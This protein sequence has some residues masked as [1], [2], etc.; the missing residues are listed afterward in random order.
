MLLRDCVAFT[1][2]LSEALEDTIAHMESDN[3]PVLPECWLGGRSDSSADDF[4]GEL[5][6]ML[7]AE[8]TARTESGQPTW[9]LGGQ[10]TR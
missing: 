7:R 3:M 2:C 8:D 9:V 6:E 4:P 1:P 10:R 5:E